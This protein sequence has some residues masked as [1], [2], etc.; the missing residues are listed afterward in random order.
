M[1]G[2]T[3]PPTSPSRPTAADPPGPAPE[4]VARRADGLMVDGDAAEPANGQRNELLAMSGQTPP[5]TS[6]SRPTAADPPGPAPET[7][8]RRADGLMVDGDAAEPANGQRNGQSVDPTVNAAAAR[9]ARDRERRRLARERE[10][11]A[12]RL[13]RLQRKREGQALARARQRD[14]TGGAGPSH[15]AVVDAVPVPGPSGAQPPVI[16]AADIA[17]ARRERDRE[18]HRL[19][20][21]R[22]SEAELAERQR[23]NRERMATARTKVR[24]G[25][26]GA[27]LEPPVAA[28]VADQPIAPPTAFEPPVVGGV[29]DV[30]PGAEAV[31]G[32]VGEVA[33]HSPDGAVDA[34]E[35]TVADAPD[36]AA[37]RR[38]AA[39]APD[40]EAVGGAVGEEA[41]HTPD[42]AVD[43]VE[44]AAVDALDGAAARRPA[45]DAPD[46]E[47][48]GGAVGEEAPHTP[49]DAVDAVEVAAVDALDG[50][51]ARR[52]AADAPDAEAVGGA[53]GEEAPHT[54]DDAVDAVE[55]AAVDAPDGAAARQ[56]AADAH[57][58]EAV[59]GADGQAPVDAPA[60]RRGDQHLLARNYVPAEFE[61]PAGMQLGR[62]D[63]V[64][65]HCGAL[66]WRA[67][68]AGA[69]CHQ[70][71]VQL[72]FHPPPPDEMVELMTPGTAF[73]DE[74]R[75]KIRA[76]NT[77]FQ[78]A[79]MGC[80]VVR[81]DG[82][83]HAAFTVQGSVCHRMGSLLPARGGEEQFMQVYFLDADE[84]TARRA[85]M[86]GGLDRAVLDILL[87]MLH[88]HNNYVRALQPALL[89]AR[90]VPNCRIVLSA[91]HRPLSEHERRFNLPIGREVAVLMPNEMGGRRDIVV[92]ERGGQLF[93]IDE[94]SRQ[95]DPLLYVLLHPRGTDGWSLELKAERGV[96]IRQYGAFHMRFRPGHFNLIPR[97]GR[98]F[99]QYLVDT[100]AKAESSRLSYVRAN[101]DGFNGFRAETIRGV[102]DALADGEEHGRAVGRR[103]VLPASVTSSPRFMMAKLQDA[104][105]Y[106]RDFGAADF[107]ITVTC[108]PAWPEIEQTLRTLYPGER[109][110]DYD[111]PCDHPDVALL[112]QLRG[113]ILGRQR[114][115][116]HTIEWQKRGLPHAHLLLWVVPAD[117]PRAEDVDT[118]VCAELP[119]PETDPELHAIVCTKMVHGPCGALNPQAVCMK[120]GRCS[121]GYPRPYLEATELPERSYPKYRRRAPEDGGQ[122]ARTPGRRGVEIDNRWIVP[123][124]PHILRALDSHVN[125]ELITH[126]MGAIRYCIKYVTK[127]SDRIMFAVQ[128]DGVVDE[129]TQY[130][131]SRYLD[132]WRQRGG[133]STDQSTSIIRRSSGCSCISPHPEVPGV[134]ASETLSR[135]YTTTPRAGEVFFL[136]LL[137]H[138][139]RGPRSYEHL[140]TVDG[141]VC[142]T[143][144]E[145]C[146]ALGLLEDGAHWARALEEASVTRFAGGLRFLFALILIEG[147]ATCDPMALWMRFADALSEDIARRQRTARAAGRRGLTEDE[148]RQQA[149]RKIAGILRRLRGRSLA[150]YGLP[151]PPVP[152]AAAAADGDDDEPPGGPEYDPAALADRV[153][154]DEPRL[155]DDQRAVYDEVLRRLDNDESGV[156]FLQ[157]PGGCGKTFLEN[158]LLAKV[159]SRGHVAVAVATS[160]IAASLLEGGTTA[161]HRFKI[162]L[163]LHPDNENVCGIDRRSP[164]ADYLRRCRLI[165]WDEAAMT[166]R[167]ATEAVDRAL[168][169]VRDRQELFGGVLTLLSGDWRQILPVVK[170]GGRA[171]VVDACLKSSPMWPRIDTMELA[172]NMR[173]L[174]GD[175]QAGEFANFLLRVGDGRLPVVAQPDSVQVPE[176]VVSP[177]RSLAALV[178]RIFPDMAGRHRDEEWLHERAILSPLNATVD[179]AN[180]AALALLPGETVTYASVDTISDDDNEDH[181]PPV[182]TEVLNAIDVSGMPSHRLQ[183]KVGAPVVLMRNLDAPR[184]VNGTL[185][186][187]LRAA[188]NVLELRIASGVARGETLF[189]PR[190]PLV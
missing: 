79:S 69:C 73:Y 94:L 91:E 120:D 13:L 89:M 56:P 187:V 133:C 50:A 51:A 27:G 143:M 64:C 40:A 53:V 152:D 107:F 158:L 118:C 42:G 54:P 75:G 16:L 101:Q 17:A 77:A 185:C 147:E 58:A 131:N 46:A 62:M 154:R 186:T 180:E 172:T 178:D 24:T 68:P 67:E 44:V 128:P 45:A 189:L 117:K 175:D 149:L 19:R 156:I 38:P 65:A 130:Q 174:N 21:E 33:T 92:R 146:S 34:V 138:S 23:R 15:Q 93:R 87:G 108:N 9:R 35:A 157:A 137:L 14:Q 122:R 81:H 28:G 123:Y 119:D 12:E 145:A 125:V 63:T 7:V 124:N 11:E 100:E 22:E 80:N 30:A 36:D 104:L 135:V 61:P 183:V 121:V 160:G 184:V 163:Q 48:V 159:R 1:S 82:A 162:P 127:G 173:A 84:A 43:A 83:Y 102:R 170:R 105:C 26:D 182:P 88:E 110:G 86:C 52:P 20:R 114:A 129:V 71:K 155:T 153:E 98:L 116:L 6:P 136:R 164:E 60:R 111:R 166:N 161:H 134:V 99:Q 177:A 18:R 57:D 169:D 179:R 113:G 115:I 39:D 31:G 47:A 95:Y 150:E 106:V 165:V 8:A 141:R 41:P 49:D 167:R 25:R 132:P 190:L 142:A 126:A 4:T 112:K 74:F 140:R 151:V 66:R 37:A 139:V 2:Q 78:L 148:V 171:E 96:T 32:A 144:R 168:Q 181:G 72:D 5:P 188:P 59:G 76:Y 3:P 90:G 97:G 55:A 85:T 29:A 176:L 109:P 103:V 70:G 10:T